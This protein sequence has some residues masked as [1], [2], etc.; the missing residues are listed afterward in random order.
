MRE[1]LRGLHQQRSKWHKAADAP[2][3]SACSCGKCAKGSEYREASGSLSKLRAFV[4]APC[5]MQE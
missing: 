3:A 4:H 5:G 1:N 2:G